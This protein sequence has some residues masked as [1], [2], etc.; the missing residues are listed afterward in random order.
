ML[1]LKSSYGGSKLRP[2]VRTGLVDSAPQP[3][4]NLHFP[5]LAI[6]HLCTQEDTYAGYRIPKGSVII[7]NSWCVHGPVFH[8][9][10]IFF[11]SDCRGLSRDPALYKDPDSVMPER[12]LGDKPELDPYLL[13][14]GFGRR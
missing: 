4:S 2:Q 14:F 12:F 11:H 7:P 5:R 8:V 3:F 13:A 6:P 10:K 9:K 1:S